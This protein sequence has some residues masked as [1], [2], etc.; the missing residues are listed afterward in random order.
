M[1]FSKKQRYVSLDER[2]EEVKVGT[3]PAIRLVAVETG[4]R[5]VLVVVGLLCLSILSIW[6][7]IYQNWRLNTSSSA[8]L[9]PVAAGS[10]SPISTPVSSCVSPPIRREWRTLNTA[11]KRDYIKAVQ[12]LATRPSQ[13]G[14]N[15]T[16]HDDFP[17]IHQKTAPTG[18]DLSGLLW[19]PMSANDLQH[20]RLPRFSHGT[21]ISSIYMNKLCRMNAVTKAFYRNPPFIFYPLRNCH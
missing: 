5:W 2:D 15:G 14:S 10:W 17:W 19:N 21:D 20:T 16:L 18:K 11:A 1:F 9:A 6:T 3:A 4:L 7:S 8:V 12:C 13:V